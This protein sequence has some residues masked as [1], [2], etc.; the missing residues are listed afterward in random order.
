MKPVIG[1]S[2]LL[3]IALQTLAGVTSAETGFQFA[4]PNHRSPEDPHVNGVRFSIF[5]GKN[6]SM[7]GLD[8]GLLALSETESLSGLALVLGISKVTGDMSG[9]GAIS[10]INVHT[11]RDSGLNAAF[12]NR[13]ND[14]SDAVD[15]AFVNIAGNGFLPVFP[16]FNFPKSSQ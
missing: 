4:A 11:G 10:L 2:L 3:A 5:H 6:Q 8:L 16:I 1:S 14:A 13:V 15:V 12:I 7:R 9:G